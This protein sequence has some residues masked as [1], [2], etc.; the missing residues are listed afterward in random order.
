MKKN[1]SIIAIIVLLIVGTIGGTYSLMRGNSVLTNTF[2]TAEYGT[3][4]IEEFKS[5]TNW[6]PGDTENKNIQIT[7]NG[8]VSMAVRISL[9]E[10]WTKKDGTSLSLKKDGLDVAIINFEN[11]NLWKKSGDYYY[12]TKELKKNETSSKFISG[13]KFN[14]NITGEY[15]CTTTENKEKCLMTNDYA[16]AIYKLKIT[17][18]TIQFDK[19]TSEWN[20]NLKEL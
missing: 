18:E 2:T 13:V 3:T 8:N 6:L 11:Q 7:N 12:Y 10:S 14:E 16:D 15:V 9:D 4:I 17:M 5:P 20:V 1:K 19:V